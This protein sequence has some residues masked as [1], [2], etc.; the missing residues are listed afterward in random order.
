MHSTVGQWVRKK[1]QVTLLHLPQRLE[2]Y[3]KMEPNVSSPRSQ[4]LTIANYLKSVQSSPFLTPWDFCL[5]S[6]EANSCSTSQGITCFWNLNVHYHIHSFRPY[7]SEIHFSII[8]H[9][10]LCHSTN[11]H[12][13]VFQSNFCGHFVLPCPLHVWPIPLI[14]IH[15]V[16]ESHNTLT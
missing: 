10:Q 1:S 13:K 9:Q 11:L 7:S 4:G 16:Q 2:H 14:L 3:S 5:L 6:W 8:L 12:H 15:S